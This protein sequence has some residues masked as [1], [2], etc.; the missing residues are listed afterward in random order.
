MLSLLLAATHMSGAAAGT[1]AAGTWTNSM[2]SINSSAG[3][4][5]MMQQQLQHQGGVA[6][7][8]QSSAGFPASMNS[9]QSA[10]MSLPGQQEAHILNVQRQQ[11]LLQQQ[12]LAGT[13]MTAGNNGPNSSNSTTTFNHLNLPTA[14]VH[15]PADQ[16][17]TPAYYARLAGAAA[18]PAGLNSTTGDCGNDMLLLMQ[19]Q[20]LMQ[21]QLLGQAAGGYSGNAAG[22]GSQQLQDMMMLDSCGF[23]AAGLTALQGMPM[24]PTDCLLPDDGSLNG[25]DAAGGSGSNKG[26]RI[27]AHAPHNPLYKVRVM[28]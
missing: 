26:D 12:L 3:Q 19:Q 23:N 2:A 1:D 22:P 4:S 24:G 20:Q 14:A 18:G 9:M 21:Q 7:H 10:M 16:A 13:G 28:V 11:L 6:Q 5:V 15:F 27:G 25:S 17:A 8:V